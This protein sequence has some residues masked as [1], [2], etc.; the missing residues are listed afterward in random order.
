MIL[1]LR[2]NY[3][4]FRMTPPI[5]N[6]STPVRALEPAKIALDNIAN[7]MNNNNGHTD[8]H[9]SKAST[10]DIRYFQVDLDLWSLKE[11]LKAFFWDNP[12]FW[13]THTPVYFFLLRVPAGV[14]NTRYPPPLF[15]KKIKR[16]ECSKS[17]TRERSPSFLPISQLAVQVSVAEAELFFIK[18]QLRR[19]FL[20]YFISS[21]AIITRKRK[22][23]S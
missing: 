10:P 17:K 8:G 1:G 20:V 9:N 14:S 19:D 22:V 7:M 3:L 21:P 15:I 2:Y 13:R 16:V 4:L 18:I 5:S 6:R 23:G 12:V 11:P